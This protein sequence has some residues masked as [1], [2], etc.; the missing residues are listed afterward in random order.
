MKSVILMLAICA[1][2]VVISA[3]RPQAQD[4]RARVLI[5]VGTV[6]AGIILGTQTAKTAEK[7]R[8]DA[9]SR[10]AEE[11]R[12]RREEQARRDAAARLSSA[13]GTPINTQVYRPPTGTTSLAKAVSQGR[14]FR[15]GPGWGT[16]AAHCISYVSS[17]CS[18]C[19]R[20]PATN[21]CV[22]RLHEKMLNIAGARIQ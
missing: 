16:T 8:K 15:L 22:V 11:E 4:M 18:P 7:H 6:A 2:A 9:E 13:L 14:L 3:D 1:P 10:R 20:N 19:D 17:V 12:K 5:G 21:I